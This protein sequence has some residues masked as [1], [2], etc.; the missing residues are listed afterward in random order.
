MEPL[1]QSLT[2]LA[3]SSEIPY[4]CVKNTHPFIGLSRKNSARAPSAPH[5]EPLCIQLLRNSLRACRQRLSSSKNSGRIGSTH[6][7]TVR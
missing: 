3:I 7:Q 6:V 5:G 1:N 2:A 4:F